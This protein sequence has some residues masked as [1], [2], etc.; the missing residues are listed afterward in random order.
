MSYQFI[1]VETYAR[2]AKGR[3]FAMR[4]IVAEAM[5]EPAACEHVKQPTKPTTIYGETDLN[6]LIDEIEEDASDA[7]DC[8]GHKLRK[9]SQLLLAGVASFPVSVSELKEDAT[10]YIRWRN[11]VIKFLQNEYGENLCSVVQHLDEEYPHVHFFVK[12]IKNGRNLDLGRLHPGRFA[13]SDRKAKNRQ[14]LYKDAMKA[15]QDRFFES[16]GKPSGM[17]RLGPKKRR[18][19]REQWKSEKESVSVVKENDFLKEQLHELQELYLECIAELGRYQNDDNRRSTHNVARQ[20]RD[21][22]APRPFR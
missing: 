17:T 1:H 22:Y 9:D 2:I 4:D 13:A 10:N 16:V 15:Y 19:T 12:P 11:R 7:V 8:I 21:V 20:I 14:K 3:K 6:R 5:R 18:L